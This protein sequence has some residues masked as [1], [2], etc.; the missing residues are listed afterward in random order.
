MKT[1]AAP[2]Y[3]QYIVCILLASTLKANIL[4]TETFVKKNNNG[5][6]ANTSVEEDYILYSND[7]IYDNDLLPQM[8]VNN[9]DMKSG[10]SN[11]NSETTNFLESE[12]TKKFDNL[13]SSEKQTIDNFS[14][15]EN[16]LAS[17]VNPLDIDI[18]FVGDSITNT[19][20]ETPTTLNDNN[21]L[22]EKHVDIQKSSLIILTE[23]NSLLKTPTP[24]E[25]IE[26]FFQK[27]TIFDESNTSQVST[28]L[29][30]KKEKS[31]KDY[32]TLDKE[33]Y[34][35]KILKQDIENIA[36]KIVED[37]LNNLVVVLYSTAFRNTNVC[38]T[39]TLTQNITTFVNAT[40]TLTVISTKSIL[41]QSTTTRFNTN[42]ETV[43]I[44]TQTLTT[45]PSKSKINSNSSNL[46][47][48]FDKVSSSKTSLPIDLTKNSDVLPLNLE[49][50]LSSRVSDP[51]RSSKVDKYENSGVLRWIN[52]LKNIFGN[53]NQSKNVDQL[54]SKKKEEFTNYFGKRSSIFNSSDDDVKKYTNNDYPL[55]FYNKYNSM[56]AAVVAVLA[57]V[58]FI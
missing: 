50:L 35:E 17:H 41:S 7:D 53:K 26:D 22:K 18:T 54:P 55:Q 39:E 10:F 24:T 30:L 16:T 37:Y 49:A 21:F 40:H 48:K 34:S 6:L 33:I 14:L 29:Q 44:E 27:D 25:D 32:N 51:I 5:I 13:S 38:S 3:S 11:E 2:A 19:L 47:K 12:L 8:D 28:I 45:I 23:N 56:M 43:S 15:V 46:A 57:V 1:I 36:K 52:K 42:T 58:L 20:I 31:T 9:F 4:N